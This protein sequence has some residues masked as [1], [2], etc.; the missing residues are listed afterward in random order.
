LEEDVAIEDINMGGGSG[1]EWR[2]VAGRLGS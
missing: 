1:A 2:E